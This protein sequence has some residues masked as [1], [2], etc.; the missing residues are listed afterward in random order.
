M[1]PKEKRYLAQARVCR[2]GSVDRGQQ[3]HVAPLCH[4]FDPKTST[5]YVATGGVTAGNLRQ[6]RRAAIECDD[7]FEDWGRLRGLVAH[8]RAKVVRRGAELERAIR[9][10]KAKFKQYREY[11][12][13]EVIALRVESVTSWGL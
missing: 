8:A 7:Y 12:I 6:R 4:A 13:D 10:L 5:A 3:P 9:L 1:S 2:I 11:D